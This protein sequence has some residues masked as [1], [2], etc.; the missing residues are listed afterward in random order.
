[1][2]IKANIRR[3]TRIK[4]CMLSENNEFEH[5]IEFS[6]HEKRHKGESSVVTY[7]TLTQKVMKSIKMRK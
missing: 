3:I 6:C 7:I 5:T 1:M 2:I 4:R